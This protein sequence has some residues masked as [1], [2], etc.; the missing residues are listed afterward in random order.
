MKDGGG[1]RVIEKG[2]GKGLE[3]FGSKVLGCTRMGAGRWYTEWKGIQM[4]IKKG[5]Q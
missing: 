2:L 4:C 1:G 5:G 3:G